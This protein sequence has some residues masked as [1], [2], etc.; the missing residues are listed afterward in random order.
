MKQI[1]APL[2]TSEVVIP[3]KCKVQDSKYLKYAHE[4]S[5]KIS[6]WLHGRW[7]AWEMG[8]LF[9]VTALQKLLRD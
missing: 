9:F 7:R 8:T 5:M 6:D 3:F 1:T 2:K 4:T